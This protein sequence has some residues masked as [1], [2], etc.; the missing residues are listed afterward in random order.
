MQTGCSKTINWKSTSDKSTVSLVVVWGKATSVTYVRWTSSH[1]DRI[2]MVLGVWAW[3]DICTQLTPDVC[4]CNVLGCLLGGNSSLIPFTDLAAVLSWQDPSHTAEAK[5]R[6][7]KTCGTLQPGQLVL[8]WQFRREARM[9]KQIL[10]PFTK[11]AAF[12]K[13]PRTAEPDFTKCD[14]FLDKHLCW[15][16]NNIPTNQSYFR[17]SLCQV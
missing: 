13:G 3:P 17:D 9:T 14:M 12:W 6:H 10:L 11:N 16:W 7:C 4:N 1:L 2:L 5:Q 15:P 8:W